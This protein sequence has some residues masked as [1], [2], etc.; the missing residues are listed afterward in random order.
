VR[1]EELAGPFP[2]YKALTGTVDASE[3]APGNFNVVGTGSEAFLMEVRG[4]FEFKTAVA[5]ANTPMALLLRRKLRE[6]RLRK[7]LLDEREH[8]M[9]VLA[10][11]KVGVGI[12]VTALTSAALL[13][14]AQKA[15]P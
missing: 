4:K 10:T 5:T 2:W 1:R 9:K 3:E 6:D 13:E 11:E 8:M 12:S 14:T 15:V 7:E